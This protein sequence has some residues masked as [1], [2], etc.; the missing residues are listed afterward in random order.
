MTMTKGELLRR[1]ERTVGG[2]LVVVLRG[3]SG[4]GKSTLASEI[5][6]ASQL[7]VTVVSADHFFYGYD[8]KYNFDP[9]LLGA[10]HGD[11]LRHFV[12]ALQTDESGIIVVDNTNTTVAECAPYMALAAAYLCDAL[13]V[14][15]SVPPSVGAERT[16][17]GVS[18]KG[19]E[20]QFYRL[21]AETANLP[22]FWEK[23]VIYPGYS[24]VPTITNA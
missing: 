6:K 21:T 10:A 23:A 2:K 17:H 24:V 15:L 13:L 14:T 4:A 1:V 19:V 5:D 12:E 7:P 11:C 20:S 22:P 8:G 3:I 9:S 18:P 16:V